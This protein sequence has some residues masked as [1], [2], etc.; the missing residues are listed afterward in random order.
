MFLTSPRQLEKD[1]Q[2]QAPPRVSRP[3]RWFDRLR[4]APGG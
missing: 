4:T 1:P 2:P 3:P